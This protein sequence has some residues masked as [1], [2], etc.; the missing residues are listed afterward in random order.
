MNVSCLLGNMR[1][2]LKDAN[3]NI[4]ETAPLT[5]TMKLHRD[6]SD[7]N[8]NKKDENPMLCQCRSSC[9]SR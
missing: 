8:D 1:A 2:Q 7:G 4:V 9:T 3:I 6:R 5:V